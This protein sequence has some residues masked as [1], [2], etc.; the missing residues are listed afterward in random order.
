MKVSQQDSLN[1]SRK[2]NPFHVNVPTHLN[3]SKKLRKHFQGAL[4]F[5][6]SSLIIPSAKF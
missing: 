3:T 6:L 2:I 1:F 5:S 4:K